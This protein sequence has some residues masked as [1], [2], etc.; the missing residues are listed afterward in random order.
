MG[1]VASHDSLVDEKAFAAVIAEDVR[2]FL[3]LS[4]FS[5][6]TDKRDQI[7]SR[8]FLGEYNNVAT[9]LEE[10]LDTYGAKH[11]SFW[12]SFREHVAVAKT[13]A[14]AAYTLNLI[15]KRIPMLR[16]LSLKQD[17][18]IATHD[19]LEMVTDVLECNADTVT[20]V[21][22]KLGFDIP[23]GHIERDYH[24][25]EIK[26]MRLRAD[27]KKRRL[28]DP[29]RTVI[30]L[31]TAFLDIAE[32]SNLLGIHS[33]IR[34]CDYPDCI[35]EDISEEKLMVIEN[36]FHSLQSLYD[37]Y[38]SESDIEDHDE[39]LVTLRSH[40]SVIYHLLDTATQ[41]SHFYERH[42]DVFNKGLKLKFVCPVSAKN[43]LNIMMTYSVAFAHAYIMSANSLCRNMVRQY[44]KQDHIRVNI[45]VYRG[46]HVRPSTMI[47][48]IIKHYGGKVI[49][50]MA[51]DEYNAASPLELFRANE[52]INARK[53]KILGDEILKLPAIQKQVRIDPDDDV[54]NLM[55]TICMDLMEKKKLIL[56]EK[57]F[58]CEGVEFQS[59]E[60]LPGYVK[61]WLANCLAAGKIDIWLNQRVEFIGDRRVLDD[62]KLLADHGYGEDSFGNNIVLP[63]E[64][65]YLRR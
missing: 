56:Y 43:L 36:K 28:K 45:P 63:K 59:G 57:D 14:Q 31:A 58:T 60:S 23:D 9:R 42:I 16:L 29:E 52:K 2:P 33:R 4:L 34:A 51:G 12:F 46:F 22:A 40:I 15:A 20:T 35:P 8:A 55:K 11:N 27:R 19:A 24:T 17:F 49:M 18:L 26:P 10:L 32:E 37:T 39:N 48:K 61:R 30:Y 41:F 53:R 62:I 47:A 6:Q 13:F 65:A 54:E 21:A 7:Q 25:E 1:T 5:S 38:L 64:L 44:S 3:E 50:R